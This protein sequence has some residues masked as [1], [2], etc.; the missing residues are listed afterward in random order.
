MP[1]KDGDVQGLVAGPA[2]RPPCIYVSHTRRRRRSIAKGQRPRLAGGLPLALQGFGATPPGRCP[3]TGGR[4]DEKPSGR[5]A[6]TRRV[7]R[8]A[9]QGSITGARLIGR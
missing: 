7:A 8:R 9:P 2:T 3:E 6:R 5:R 4:V 1:L